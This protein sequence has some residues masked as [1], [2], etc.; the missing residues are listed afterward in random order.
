MY[1]PPISLD[2]SYTLPFL[3]QYPKH[4]GSPLHP[5]L[6]PLLNPFYTIGQSEKKILNIVA[7]YP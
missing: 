5:L 6:S 7:K 1:V 4:P 2:H 3:N